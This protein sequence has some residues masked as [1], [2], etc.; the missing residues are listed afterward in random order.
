MGRGAANHPPIRRVHL[1]MMTNLQRYSADHRYLLE[2]A[3]K[4]AG[5][6][7]PVALDTDEF[8]APLVKAA[9]RGPVLPIDGVLVRDWDPDSRRTNPGIQI[10]MR[11]YEIE[12]I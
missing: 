9:K 6:S 2:Q 5:F 10:G 8:Y 11:L 3:G 1:N 7:S 12:G 4:A